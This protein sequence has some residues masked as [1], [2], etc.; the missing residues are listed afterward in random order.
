MLLAPGF[1][2]FL[3]MKKAETKGGHQP[4]TLHVTR[5]LPTLPPPAPPSSGMFDN[6]GVIEL[7]FNLDIA[8]KSLVSTMS[9]L[10]ATMWAA[11]LLVSSH[12]LWPT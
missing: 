9:A 3:C 2:P 6:L 7:P 8:K 5:L 10:Y 12:H 1:N 4:A 11:S